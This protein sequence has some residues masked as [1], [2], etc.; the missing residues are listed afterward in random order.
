MALSQISICDHTSEQKLEHREIE[1]M[2][3]AISI[4]QS[5]ELPHR[6]EAEKNAK[7]SGK[8]KIQLL[9]CFQ[10][11]FLRHTD[12]CHSRVL[13][14]LNLLR[15]CDVDVTV[16]SYSNNRSW[17]WDEKY[18][19]EFSSRYPEWRLVLEEDSW[20]RRTIGR[21]RTVLSALFPSL[22]DKILK[23]PVP[24]IMPRLDKLCRNDRFD[25]VMFNNADG[26]TQ[27]NGIPKGK[28]IVDMH[29]FSALESFQTGKPANWRAMVKLR[30][31][32]CLLNVT[33]I[34]WCISQSEYTVAKEVLPG[35]KI[36]FIPANADILNDLQV[37]TGE[38]EYKLLFLG[39]NNRWNADALLKF[40][41][42]YET[43]E[44]RPKLAVAGRVCDDARIRDRASRNPDISLLGYQ[45]D[46]VQLY[47]NAAATICPVEGTGTKIKV[48]ESLAAKRPVFAAEGAMR[49]LAP[50]YECCVFPLREDAVRGTL[51]NRDAVANASRAAVAYSIANGTGKLINTILSDLHALV[52]I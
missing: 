35:K 31:E 23:T 17:P 38:E 18:K 45:E 6:R 47:R 44:I 46:L 16:Y 21:G 36:S 9:F 27:I 39:S 5:C 2:T 50:G 40:L 1:Q 8:R 12:G 15:L 22:G 43:W 28:I 10:G 25:Y 4:N 7:D 42:S 41:G 3:S 24:L 30:K 51:Y 14:I 19:S 13:Q 29:D 20:T 48:V 34:I 26:L 37:A 11:C 49:G 32:I 52:I 33:D